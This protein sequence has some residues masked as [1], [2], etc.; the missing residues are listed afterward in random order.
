MKQ[1]YLCRIS[2]NFIEF[3]MEPTNY[4]D[5]FV[6]IARQSHGNNTE[7]K[8]T[9]EVMINNN[10]KM[11]MKPNTYLRHSA[12][13]IAVF[14]CLLNVSFSSTVLMPPGTLF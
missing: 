8:C 4:K 9:Q 7:Q 6:G 12:E 10:I 3:Y 1:K 13:N 14:R 2:F 11:I 5:I